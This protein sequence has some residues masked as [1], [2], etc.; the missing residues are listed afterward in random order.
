MRI[1]EIRKIT[2]EIELLTAMHIGGSKDDLQIGGV[3][4]K[5]IK[6]PVSGEAYIPGSSLKGKMRSQKEKI[7]GAK[8]RDGTS[9]DRNPCGCGECNICKVFGAHKNTESKVAPSRLIVRDAYFTEET[10]RLFEQFADSNR[11]FYEEKP[12]NLINRKTGTAEHPRFTE[13]VPKGSKF[14]LEL[15]INVYDV[16]NG[17][18]LEKFVKESLVL[19]EESYLGGSGSRGYGKVRFNNLKTDIIKFEKV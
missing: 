17:D 9:D 11:D 4:N 14:G 12:E 1:K 16:D 13:R 7:L 15:L 3:D 5:V 18:E 8:K 10:R 6:D 19:V 2:G